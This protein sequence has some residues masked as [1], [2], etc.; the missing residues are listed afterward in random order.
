MTCSRCWPPS[1][2]RVGVMRPVSSM[3][4]STDAR[5][6]SSTTA[7]RA[8]WRR[9][10][11]ARPL[12]RSGPSTSMGSS[13]G[14]CGS[15]FA[16]CIWWD[17][18]AASSRCGRGPGTTS[19]TIARYVSSPRHPATCDNREWRYCM[20]QRRLGSQ[21]LEGSSI[22]LGCMGMSDFY[23]SASDRD[24]RESIATIH[25]AAELGITL[26]DTADMYG[27]FTNEELVGRA[28]AGRREQYVVA[29]K[30]GFERHADG[31][32]TP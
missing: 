30:F 23:G 10:D 31:S 32:Q 19:S 17:S 29:T 11:G 16:F 13:A 26:L 20:E 28:I 24:E 12:P 21:G 1:P 15:S 18:A 9:W 27:P 3:P 7:T 8:R 4:G 22:G 5:T 2:S 14:S 25:R 6:P